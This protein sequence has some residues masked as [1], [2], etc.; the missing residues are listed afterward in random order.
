[1][2]G[3]RPLAPHCL[4]GTALHR[5][6]VFTSSFSLICLPTPASPAYTC[7]WKASFCGEGLEAGWR[8]QWGPET[9]MGP[10]SSLPHHRTILPS[11]LHFQ[12]SLLPLAN[13]KGPAALRC[14]FPF[15][16]PD[17]RNR[18]VSLLA[19]GQPGARQWSGRPARHMWPQGL[20]PV[21]LPC[22]WLHLDSPWSR[23]F[24]PTLQGHFT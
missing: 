13:C 7:V 8:A 21:L 4:W 19:P 9:I 6:G 5:Y 11:T 22:S 16:W 18:T 12:P 10:S 2:K 15:Q 14:P 3:D 23:G 20:R 1:M 24:C 17:R